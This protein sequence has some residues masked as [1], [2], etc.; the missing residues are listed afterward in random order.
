[1]TPPSPVLA[2]V[3]RSGFVEGRHRGALVALDADGSIA[4]SMGDVTRPVFLRSAAK[5]AQ[6]VAALRAGLDLDGELLALA[7]A[8]HSG[9]PFHLEG[10]RRILLRAGLTPAALHT[11]PQYPLGERAYDDYLRAGGCPDRVVM[12]CSGKHAAWLA[13]CATNGWDTA[14]YLEPAHPIQQLVLRTVEDLADE[15][16]SH[17]GVDGCGAPVPAIGLVGLARLFR[18]LADPCAGTPQFRVA[19]AMRAYPE[20]VA[21]SGRV[22]TLLMRAVPGLIAKMGAE[23]VQGVALADGRAVA[24]KVDDGSVRTLAPIVVAALRRLGV[25]AP[26]LDGIAEVVLTGGGRPVGVI[27]AAF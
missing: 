9:E 1:M 13:A 5:P 27:R 10:V 11:P 4:F 22:D 17:L 12:N 14:T 18:A 3:V 7:A 26:E 16:M 15:R 23:A 8:S 24:F 25:D 6:A 19:A 21:G 2:E 20:Y